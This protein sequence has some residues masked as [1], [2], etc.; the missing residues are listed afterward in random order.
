MQMKIPQSKHCYFLAIAQTSR[1]Q[2]FYYKEHKNAKK[3]ETRS[4]TLNK[5]LKLKN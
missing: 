4:I 2:Q 3:K 5:K 1:K